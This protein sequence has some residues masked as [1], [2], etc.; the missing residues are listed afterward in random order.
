M[1]LRKAFREFIPTAPNEVPQSTVVVGLFLSVLV[2]FPHEIL[3]RYVITL[4]LDHV[5]AMTYLHPF[6]LQTAVRFCLT[7]DW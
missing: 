3:L 5:S 4:G 2:Q 6:H 7:Y 1:R